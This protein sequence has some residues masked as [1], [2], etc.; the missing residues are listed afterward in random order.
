LAA[1]TVIWLVRRFRTEDNRINGILRDFDRENPRREPDPRRP[2]EG[3]RACADVG[4]TQLLEAAQVT[5]Y[6]E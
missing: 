3:W 2:R 6:P 1:A 5:G 4:N